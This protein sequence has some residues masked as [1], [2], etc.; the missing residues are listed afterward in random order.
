MVRESKHRKD[1][2]KKPLLSL[3]ERRAKKHEKNQH[4]T[5]HHIEDQHLIE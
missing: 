1:Q 4:K 5:A 2:R 3:K